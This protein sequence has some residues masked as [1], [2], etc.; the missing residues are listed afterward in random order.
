MPIPVF[1]MR[2]AFEQIPAALTEPAQAGGCSGVS[3]LWRVPLPVVRPGALSVA[4][5]AFFSARNEFPAAPVLLPD[6]AEFT[7]P[8]FPT[9]LVPRHPGGIDRR[10]RRRACR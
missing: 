7:L 1:L 10:V 6:G 9:V 2:D 8:V 5:F 3:S 4:L